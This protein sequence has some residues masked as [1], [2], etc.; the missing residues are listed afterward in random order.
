VTTSTKPPAINDV[1]TGEMQPRSQNHLRGLIAT[2]PL[3]VLLAACG[4]GAPS[5]SSPTSSPSSKPTTPSPTLVATP[6]PT[7]AP[8]PAPVPPLAVLSQ[9]QELKV[10]NSQGVEQWSLS[11][12]AMEKIFGV[13]ASQ[14][15]THGFGINSEIGGSHITLFYNITPLLTKVA[16]LSRAGNLVGSS[17]VPLTPGSFSPIEVSPS[18]TEWT[19]I[20]DQTPNATGE[21]HGVVEVGGLGE[22]VR[23]VYDWVAPVGFTETVAAWTNTGIIMFRVQSGGCGVGFHPDF[24]SFVINPTT[25]SL[26]DLFSGNENYLGASS[27]VTVASLGN[28]DHSV[29]IDG[30]KYSESKSSIAGAYISPDGAHVAVSRIN[31]SGGCAGFIPKLTVEMVTVANQSHVDLQNLDAD[32]WWTDDQFI[33]NNLSGNTW[34]YNLQGGA[35]SEICSESSGWGF[36]GVLTG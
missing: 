33:A 13:S 7:A 3:A 22:G 23:T 9:G 16:V 17:T 30:V 24:A 28:D 34:I 20:V 14:A 21:H 12:A 32:G 26:S 18:G 5:S 29:L 19:W 11:N 15:Q 6:S 1:H 36:S 10:V 35:V 2:L 4:T 27:G 8:T 25:G 31:V